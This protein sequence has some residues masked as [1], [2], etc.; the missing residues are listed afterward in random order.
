M[1]CSNI[2]GN[3]DSCNEPAS[4]S[5]CECECECVT[6]RFV[7]ADLLL[8]RLL[9]HL[10]ILIALSPFCFLVPCTGFGSFT[11]AVQMSYWQF[12]DY[13]FMSRSMRYVTKW[14]YLTFTTTNWMFILFCWA[15]GWCSR[16][17]IDWH[18]SGQS[19]YQSSKAKLGIRFSIHQNIILLINLMKI[20]TFIMSTKCF[21]SV[22]AHEDIVFSVS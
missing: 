14:T 3:K 20:Q 7:D 13:S 1:H 12:N 22:I 2:N 21:W 17:I 18:Y 11:I 9:F 8:M 4:N 16:D 6:I 19:N 10:E 15:F 5:K